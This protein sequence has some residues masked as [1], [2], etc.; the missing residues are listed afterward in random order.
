M[1]SQ[2]ET[3]MAVN[4]GT[5]T[6]THISEK[7]K[8]KMKENL[9]NKKLAEEYTCLRDAVFFSLIKLKS[10]HRFWGLEEYN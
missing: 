9:E 2:I 5:H 7:Q 6:G 10:N 8:E 4:A 1:L 3:D